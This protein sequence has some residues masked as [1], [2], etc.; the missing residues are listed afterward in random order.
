MCD[1]SSGDHVEDYI[2]NSR[3]YCVH[4]IYFMENSLH[5]SLPLQI[6]SPKIFEHSPHSRHWNLISK[7]PTSMPNLL[8]NT[9]PANLWEGNI[10]SVLPAAHT[11]WNSRW[12][13]NL[14]LFSPQSPDYRHDEIF[15][16]QLPLWPPFHGLWFPG[17]RTWTSPCLLKPSGRAVSDIP[18][19]TCHTH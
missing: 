3:L 5:F 17:S 6:I 8:T 4:Q 15:C 2:Y 19:T 18:A 11:N 14:W 12:G 16:S 1:A 7:I 9:L 10:Y 13:P